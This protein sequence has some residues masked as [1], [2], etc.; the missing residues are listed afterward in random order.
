M[1][2][3]T[4]LCTIKTKQQAP[5]DTPSLYA[6]QFGQRWNWYQSNHPRHY[7][8]HQKQSAHERRARRVAPTAHNDTS[9]YTVPTA[10]FVSIPNPFTTTQFILCTRGPHP[11]NPAK[12]P[13]CQSLSQRITIQKIA[14]PHER[15]PKGSQI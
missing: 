9:I 12:T 8:A 6:K 15:H 11:T 4:S 2:I 10:C 14:E 5:V 3:D 7:L 1:P 13:Q